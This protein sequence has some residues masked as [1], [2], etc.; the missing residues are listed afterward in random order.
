M[1]SIIEFMVV[2]ACEVNY[3]ISL[4][5]AVAGVSAGCVFCLTLQEKPP[6]GTTNY[7]DMWNPLKS[8]PNFWLTNVSRTVNN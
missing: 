6:S 3:F 2:A 8:P 5:V 1:T 7:I 4:V